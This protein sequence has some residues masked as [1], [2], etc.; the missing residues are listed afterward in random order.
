[1]GELLLLL[2]DM[3]MS[4][5]T[6]GGDGRSVVI[7]FRNKDGELCVQEIFFSMQWFTG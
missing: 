4:P 3:V 2:V 6:P 1:M 5:P 7:V